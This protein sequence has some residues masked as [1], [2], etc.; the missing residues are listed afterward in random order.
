MNLCIHFWNPKGSPLWA[1]VV[2][3]LPAVVGDLWLD[4]TKKGKLETQPFAHLTINGTNIPSG[5]VRLHPAW[6]ICQESCVSPSSGQI[7]NEAV[8]ESLRV[9]AIFCWQS[10]S[11]KQSGLH[12]YVHFQLLRMGVYLKRPPMGIVIE[13]DNFCLCSSRF[14]CG[15]A[16]PS[17]LLTSQEG[18]YILLV[19]AQPSGVLRGPARCSW[20]A[21][22]LQKMWHPP[23]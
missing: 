2:S 1:N 4:L 8:T 13:K 5:K 3:H 6:K 9:L 21:V 14:T 7:C 10:T 11:W 19:L 20:K 12:H 16:D 22:T 15:K 18:E 23:S 17:P